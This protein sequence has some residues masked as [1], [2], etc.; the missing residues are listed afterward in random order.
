MAMDP[1]K[2]RWQA[3]HKVMVI[4]DK[5]DIYLSNFPPY[6]FP[7]GLALF[8]SWILSLLI[9]RYNINNVIRIVLL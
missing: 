4:G 6:L 8:P 5:L 9:S 1:P 7:A 3:G 2:G